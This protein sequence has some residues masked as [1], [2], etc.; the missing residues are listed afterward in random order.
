MLS[1]IIIWCRF[2]DR[3]KMRW[4]NIISFIYHQEGFQLRL[5]LVH[6]PKVSFWF[7]MHLLYSFYWIWLISTCFVCVDLNPSNPVVITE[8][9]KAYICYSVVCWGLLFV[10]VG[11]CM[12]LQ[13]TSTGNVRYGEWWAWLPICSI[14]EARGQGSWIFAKVLFLC[15]FMG[16]AEVIPGGQDWGGG[17]TGWGLG[18]G[19]AILC[20][21]KKNICRL[22][23]NRVE[24]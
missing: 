2:S 13:W 21:A 7:I 16:L 10:A 11:V 18:W 20:L 14:R 12:A 23:L 19:W 22:L 9:K 6:V 5:I 1:P 15:F 8:Q 17:G 3:W 24:F 4:N